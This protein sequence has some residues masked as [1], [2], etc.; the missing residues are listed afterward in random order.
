MK[1]TDLRVDMVDL[2]TQYQHIREEVNEAILQV[3]ASTRYINGPEVDRFGTELSSF[4][5][6]PHVIPC[7]NG[8]DA[9]MAALMA[10]ELKPGDEVITTPFT[11]VAT[12]EVIVALG[13]VPVFADID[14]SSFNID[15]ESVRSCITGKTRCI[16]PVHLFGQACDM[17]AI[18]EIAGEHDLYVIEDNAQAL[19]SY[20]FDK[21]G[22]KMMA[23]TI[24]HIGTTSFF[25]AKNLG[26]YGDGG[27]IFTRDSNLALKLKEIV[28]HGSSQRY[29]YNRVGMNSRLDTIQAAIL[30]IKLKR[31][32][33]YNDSRQKAAN[34]Y[35][36]LFQN[37]KGISIPTETTQTG[38]HVYHQYTLRIPRFRDQIADYLTTQNIACAIYYP[39]CLHQQTPY[40]QYA[41]VPLP[42]AEKVADEVLSLPM[43]TELTREVQEYVADALLQKLNELNQ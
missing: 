2:Y 19:G 5:D 18:M 30:S 20:A 16:I 4:L 41:R 28:N 11:F 39:L 35:K 29:Y 23:G 3:V 24:G 13:L 37:K 7:A 1:N 21:Q 40:K 34:A 32:N 36:E 10:L 26:C 15:P 9:L 43:H 8:T 38:S 42:E 17:A 22:T 14:P 31:L 25:P 6:V 27:A 33:L 12:A